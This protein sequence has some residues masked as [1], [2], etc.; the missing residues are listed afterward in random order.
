MLKK[1]L[2]DTSLPTVFS[3]QAGFEKDY[4]T[5]STDPSYKQECFQPPSDL[6]K[7]DLERNLFT[8]CK[9]LLDSKIFATHQLKDVATKLS[10]LPVYGSGESFD[11]V[12][13]EYNQESVDKQFLEKKAR[14][15]CS[16]TMKDLVKNISME[17]A[18]I[19][20]YTLTYLLSLLE[21]TGIEEVYNPL[22]E[23]HTR[24]FASSK[25]ANPSC[26]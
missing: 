2:Q 19:R 21:T 12:F 5:I 17:E 8:D 9:Q 4:K 20:C 6:F 26:N 18:K 23:N 7:L 1:N 25:E 13:K 22:Q 10:Q 3:E 15:V 24:G 16:K 14:L 11:S